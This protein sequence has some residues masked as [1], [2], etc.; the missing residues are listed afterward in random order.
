MVDILIRNVDER[1]ASRLK[2]IAEQR[3]TSVQQ[4]ARDL[5]A[6]GTRLTREDIVRRIEARV[7]RMKPQTS[8][9]TDIIRA[10]RDG[11]IRG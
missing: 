2:E 10:M 7:A 1:V 9:S 6:S 4:V 8:D 5:L 3:N 11:R